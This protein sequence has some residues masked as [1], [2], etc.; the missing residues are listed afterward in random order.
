VDCVTPAIGRACLDF[1]QVGSRETM[2]NA[3][4]KTIELRDGPAR[5]R[6]VAI[7]DSDTELTL[8]VNPDDRFGS[9]IVY[10]PSGECN[11]E[12]LELWSEYLE[13]EWP[14]TVPTDL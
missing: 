9:W 4:S 13:S 2:D 1:G 12:G 10:R 8:P 14:E 6:R 7:R 5:G 3:L 11:A